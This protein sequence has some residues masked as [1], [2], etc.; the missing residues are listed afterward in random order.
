MPVAKERKFNVKR[1]NWVFFIRSVKLEIVG[2]TIDEKIKNPK[3]ISDVAMISIPN[4]T[5]HSI[6]HKN[7]KDGLQIVAGRC[8]NAIT[9]KGFSKISITKTFATSKI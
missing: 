4:T 2:E 1:S 3:S 8:V 6:K 7:S 5:T 9:F